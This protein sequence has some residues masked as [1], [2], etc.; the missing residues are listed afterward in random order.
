[1]NTYIGSVAP[2]LLH[3]WLLVAA[4]SLPHRLFR[5]LLTFG[6]QLNPKRAA[7]GYLERD[8]GLR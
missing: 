6:K 7:I 5:R 3:P 4:Q 1:M 2:F 8:F